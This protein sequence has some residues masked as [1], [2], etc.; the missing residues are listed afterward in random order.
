MG[1]LAGGPLPRP[2]SREERGGGGRVAGAVWVAIGLA[3]HE[4]HPRP[5]SR[6]ERG[7]AVT[8]FRMQ[9]LTAHLPRGEGRSL[10]GRGAEWREIRGSRTGDRGS[11]LRRVVGVRNGL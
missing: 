2:L 4:P 1:L 10:A 9:R 5:L 11:P 8:I 6:E 7:V 3:R